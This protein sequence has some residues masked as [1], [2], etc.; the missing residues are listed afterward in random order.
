MFVFQVLFLLI[1]L[2]FVKE[3]KIKSHK[4]IISEREVMY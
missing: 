1:K 4:E 3:A 2:M